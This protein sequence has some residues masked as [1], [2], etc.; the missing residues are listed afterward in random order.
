MRETDTEK[1]Q[2]QEQP[3]TPTHTFKPGA[4]SEYNRRDR[5][6]EAL[7][8]LAAG[9]APR[10]PDAPDDAPPPDGPDAPPAVTRRRMP[11][12]ISPAADD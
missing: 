11:V 3:H 9:V 7:P 1:N 6:P 4:S 2:G 5:P 8:R 10:P 12:G